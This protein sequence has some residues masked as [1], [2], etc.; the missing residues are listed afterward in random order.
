MSCSLPQPKEAQYAIHRLVREGA[1]LD[2]GVIVS[3]LNLFSAHGFL[4]ECEL[5]VNQVLPTLLQTVPLK[6]WHLTPLLASY[7]AAGHL[8]EAVHTYERIYQ[9]NTRE[10][11]P[12]SGKPVVVAQPNFRAFAEGLKTPEQA[13]QAVQTLKKMLENRK[14]PP[15]IQLVNGIIH[16]CQEHQLLDA[17]TELSEVL[18]Q[19]PSS[20]LAASID[21]STFNTLLSACVPPIPSRLFPSLDKNVP[22][23]DIERAESLLTHLRSGAFLR[24]TPNKATYEHLIDI[25]LYAPFGSPTWELAFD[26][27]EEMKH[28]NILPSPFV[29]VG[30]LTRLLQERNAAQELARG[31][32]VPPETPESDNDK[33]IELVLQEMAALGY[34]GGNDPH[35]RTH[36]VLSRIIRSR[37]GTAPLKRVNEQ[38]L[39]PAND[40]RKMGRRPPQQGRRGDR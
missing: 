10:F 33:R 18:F 22:Q 24:L 2:E 36:S 4:D 8:E 6:E 20:T 9:E 12:Q 7:M 34:L 35:A 27:L 3:A 29:Y 25:Y 40:Y 11:K 14:H 26:Y 37:I 15:P 32:A 28:Y 17:I 23:S 31:I 1:D 13:L 19:D 5:L 16:A 39:G 30:L 38:L 21:I